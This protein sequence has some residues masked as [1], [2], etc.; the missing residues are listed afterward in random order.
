MADLLRTIPDDDD[1]DEHPMRESSH[2]AEPMKPSGLVLQ[3]RV[4]EYAAVDQPTTVVKKKKGRPQPQ[5]PS[6]LSRPCL[7]W[8]GRM[9][10][11]KEI[12]IAKSAPV[13]PAPSS[14]AEVAKAQEPPAPSASANLQALVP[15]PSSPPSIVPLG[16]DP[17]A[18]PNALGHALFALTQLHDDLQGADRR[19]ASGRL[20]LAVAASEVA[21]KDAEAAK[22]RC[23]VAEAELET[24]RN[25]RAAEARQREA[26]EEKLKARE[27][28]E[29]DHLEKLKQEVEAEKVLLEAKANVL[30]NDH[31]AFDSLEKRSCKAL[32]ELYVRGLK[33]PLVTA[34]E[35][36]AELLPQLV[37]AF[38]GVANGVGPMV[39][40]GLAPRMS[41]LPLGRPDHHD[42]TMG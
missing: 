16:R 14:L 40:G 32:R 15:T 7:L 4:R 21:L 12:S 8:R 31:A 29:R 33:E 22:E 30:T 38:E 36:P 25:E 24:L 28:A 18:S 41:Q 17:P 34:E 26:W 27:D 23:Q 5:R 1:D 13:G 42:E 20:E 11:E 2:P 6:T 10:M 3:K 37:T 35:G 19:L 9:P 39:E